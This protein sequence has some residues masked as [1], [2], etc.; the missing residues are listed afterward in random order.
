MADQIN[1]E[2]AG[3]SLQEFLDSCHIVSHSTATV[4]GYKNAITGKTKRFRVFFKEI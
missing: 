1:Y 3:Q 4:N 2:N